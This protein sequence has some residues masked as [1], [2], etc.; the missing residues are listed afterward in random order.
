MKPCGFCAGTKRGFA[1]FPP[2]A[3]FGLS[4]FHM[5]DDKGKERTGHIGTTALICSDCGHIE[6]FMESALQKFASAGTEDNEQPDT[7]EGET[8]DA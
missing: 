4:I 1:G 2:G 7:I 3:H 6:L 5:K 8:S